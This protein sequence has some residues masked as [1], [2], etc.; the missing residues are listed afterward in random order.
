[1]ALTLNARHWSISCGYRA[2]RSPSR[3]CI[4]GFWPSARARFSVVCGPMLT[5]PTAATSVCFGLLGI[6]CNGHSYLIFPLP[7]HLSLFSVTFQIFNHA[8]GSRQECLHKTR[9]AVGLLLSSQALRLATIRKCRHNAGLN[10][11]SLQSHCL[12]RYATL[13]QHPVRVY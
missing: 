9:H 11:I 10:H 8:A 5:G 1:M 7:L 3:F 12:T 4:S 6:C 2:S 13:L